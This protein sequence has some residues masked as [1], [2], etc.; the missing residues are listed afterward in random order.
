MADY[1][2]FRVTSFHSVIPSP[3]GKEMAMVEDVIE[4]LDLRALVLE[5]GFRS[6]VDVALIDADMA[7][8]LCG[9]RPDLRD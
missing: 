9:S 6:A 5:A 8:E 3:A 1:Y 4:N 2:E 7:E